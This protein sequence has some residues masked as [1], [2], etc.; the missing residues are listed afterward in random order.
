LG[1][2]GAFILERLY[3]WYKD[4]QNENKLKESLRSELEKCLALL[5]GQGNLLPTMMWNSAVTSG[6]VKLL[7]YN[8]RT[9]L[10]GFYFEIENHNYEAKRVRDSAVVSQTLSIHCYSEY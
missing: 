1:V 2:L 8:E 5:T 4:T 10:S 9:Q 6:D 3:S 7:S